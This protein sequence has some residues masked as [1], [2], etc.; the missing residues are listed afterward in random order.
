VEKYGAAGQ[1]T[2]GNT[3]GCTRFACRLTKAT[4]TFFEYVIFVTLAQQ[5][6]LSKRP[7]M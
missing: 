1:A 7:S 6:W 2:D 4:D 5:Q 3:T